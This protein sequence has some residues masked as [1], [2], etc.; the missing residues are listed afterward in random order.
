MI[1]RI[2]LYIIGILIISI[3]LSYMY[4]YTNLFTIGYTFKEY[5]FYI[6]TR[7]ECL[8]IILGIIIVVVSF[9]KGKT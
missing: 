2:L 4:L 8:M 3:S 9:R 1:L 7:Y 5:L 6:L